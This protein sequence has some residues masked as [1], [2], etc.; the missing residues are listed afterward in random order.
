[1]LWGGTQKR[2]KVWQRAAGTVAHWIDWTTHTWAKV[3]AEDEIDA[4]I[5]AISCVRRS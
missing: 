2:G 4:N 5:R 3:S 1:M